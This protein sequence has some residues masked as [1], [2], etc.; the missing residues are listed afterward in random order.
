LN[1][2]PQVTSVRSAASIRQ[3]SSIG[4]N[5]PSCGNTMVARASTDQDAARGTAPR[6]RSKVPWV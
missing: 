6:S 3:I 4:L 5:P 2:A 1:A